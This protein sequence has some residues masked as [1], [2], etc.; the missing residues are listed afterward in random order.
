MVLI[1]LL[2]FDVHVREPERFQLAINNMSMRK[3]YYLPSFAISTVYIMAYRIHG[4]IRIFE[5]T[6][7][8]KYETNKN[9]LAKHLHQ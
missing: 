7:I 6:S 9:V 4:S 3:E 2:L 8:F 1:Q 5:I